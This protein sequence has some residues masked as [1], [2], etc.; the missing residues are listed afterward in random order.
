MKKALTTIGSGIGVVAGAL[1]IWN[2]VVPVINS[3]FSAFGTLV[4]N[5]F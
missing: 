4:T 2:V 1:I 5:L 3:V